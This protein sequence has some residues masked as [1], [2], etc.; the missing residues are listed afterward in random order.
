[1]QSQY[2]FHHACH[3]NILE[4]VAGSAYTEMMGA[5]SG[6][7][8]LLF[9]RFQ[10]HRQLVNKAQFEDSFTS[11]LTAD[12]VANAKEDLGTILILALACRAHMLRLQ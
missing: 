10:T 9:K 4:L 7:Q 2:V 11:Q 5:Y 12:A 3:P 1:M 6:I 8:I